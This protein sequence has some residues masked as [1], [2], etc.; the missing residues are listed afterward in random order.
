MRI[1][2][3]RAKDSANI[4]PVGH[5]L[6]A[7]RKRRVDRLQVERCLRRGTITEGPYVPTNS[8]T[9]DWRCNMHAHIGG[10]WIRIVVEIAAGT[11]LLVIT[12]ILE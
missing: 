11:Q 8:R 4:V 10:E 3:A 7:M 5:A 2:R 1:I 9:G 12:A 6:R